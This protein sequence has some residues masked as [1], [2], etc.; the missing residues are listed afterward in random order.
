MGQTKWN[1]TRHFG[2]TFVVFT[3]YCSSFWLILCGK[4]RDV[5]NW[6]SVSDSKKWTKFRSKCAAERCTYDGLDRPPL[7]VPAQAVEPA[8]A[9]LYRDGHRAGVG[10]GQGAAFAGS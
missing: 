5:G 4:S 7:P 3:A 6:I 10:A 9:A 1:K 2:T 8:V